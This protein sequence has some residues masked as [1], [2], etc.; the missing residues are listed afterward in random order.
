MTTRR[1]RWIV[2]SLVA[3]AFLGWT[4]RSYRVGDAF[5]GP[6]NDT[7]SA[8]VNSWRGTAAIVFSEVAWRFRAP[9]GHWEIPL[10]DTYRESVRL[11]FSTDQRA[12]FAGI[13]NHTVCW[14]IPLPFLL[15]FLGFEGP[16]WVRRRRA[17]KRVDA[18]AG[19]AIPD[20][21]KG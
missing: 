11:G 17:K 19:E 9:W 5:G 18:D 13:T 8:E 4:I 15:L 12:G 7:W 20:G 3:V 1:T 21:V 6:L 16:A 14:P 10:T 2:W